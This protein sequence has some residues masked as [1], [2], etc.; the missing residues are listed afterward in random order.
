[1][2]QNQIKQ[3]AGERSTARKPALKRLKTNKLMLFALTLTVK[4]NNIIV[5]N[6]YPKFWR[7]N[8]KEKIDTTGT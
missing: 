6:A 3:L 8:E 2:A 1:M 5:K 7:K 4:N